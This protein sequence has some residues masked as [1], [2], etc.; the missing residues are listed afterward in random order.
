MSNVLVDNKLIYLLQKQYLGALG[1]IEG[2]YNTTVI[3]FID[4]YDVIKWCP[5]CDNFDYLSM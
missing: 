5:Y 4:F 1:L 2:H 3:S